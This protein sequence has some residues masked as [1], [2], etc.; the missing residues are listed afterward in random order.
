MKSKIRV[1]NSSLTNTIYAGNVQKNG[2]TWCAN[3]TDVTLEALVA[4][5]EHVIEFG[6]N[7]IVTDEEGNPVYTISVIKHE[8]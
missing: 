2:R 3:K 1:A 4:V 6:K 8:D 7:V 5:S